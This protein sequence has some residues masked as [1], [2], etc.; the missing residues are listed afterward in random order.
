MNLEDIAEALVVR[1]GDTLV[2]RVDRDGADLADLHKF[3]ETLKARAA[4][5]GFSAVVIA[6]EQIG[7]ARAGETA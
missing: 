1:P 2:V 4:E 7:V 6:A 3:A 5:L